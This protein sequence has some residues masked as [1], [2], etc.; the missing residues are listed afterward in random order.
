[1]SKNPFQVNFMNKYENLKYI[2]SNAIVLLLIAQFDFRM[3]DDI[4]IGVFTLLII[5]FVFIYKNYLNKSHF[6][7]LIILVSPIVID[8]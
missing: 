3:T 2:F 5:I 4:V 8:T 7:F 1:M 6:L